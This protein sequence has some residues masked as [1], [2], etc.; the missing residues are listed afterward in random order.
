MKL[1]SKLLVAAIC[2]AAIVPAMAQE[3]R[4]SISAYGNLTSDD[5]S[6]SGN[7][8]LGYGYLLTTH[9]EIGVNLM[10]IISSTNTGTSKNTTTMTM[11]GGVAQYYFRTVGSAGINP[12]LKASAFSI[13]GGGG[14]S[15]TRAGGYVGISI[16]AG[17]SAEMFVE[18]GGNSTS[19][20][21][22]GKAQTGTE[23]NFG[24]KYRF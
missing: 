19:S 20:S 5:F 2:A 14:G 18:A 1:V 7:V 13:S 23:A 21:G 22:G 4:S 3:K 17:E 10:E 24:M 16:P 6:T 12:Y 11:I 9:I 15:T 8:N